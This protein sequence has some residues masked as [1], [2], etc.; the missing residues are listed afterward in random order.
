M[1]YGIYSDNE[2]LYPDSI[3]HEHGKKEIRLLAAKG[4]HAACQILFNGVEANRPIE[5]EIASSGR[6][7]CEVYRLIDIFVEKNTGPEEFCLKEGELAEGY[8]TRPAPFRVYDALKPFGGHEVTDKATEALYLAF[9]IDRTTNPGT[10]HASVRVTFGEERCEIPCTLEVFDAEVPSK[11]SL[12]IS[13]WFGIN[14]MASRYGLEKWSEAHWDMIRKYGVLMRRV[15]QT[16]FWIPSELIEARKNEDG[17]FSFDFGR[18]KRFVEMYL[19]LGFTYIEGNLIAYRVQFKDDHFVVNCCGDVIPA[20]SHEG[21]DYISQYLKAW[22]SFLIENGWLDITVQHVAD[23][24]TEACV[25]EYRILSGIVRKFMPGTKIIEAVEY[26]EPYDL[27]GSVD[28]WVPKNNLYQEYR[29]DFERFRRQGDELWFYTCCVPGGYFLNRLWDMPLIR[30]RYLH[31]GNYIYNLSGYLHWGLNF[32][33]SEEDPFNQRNL[34][35]PP[36]DTHI[37]YPGDDGPWG[38]M[39]FEAMRSG[40]ED[41]ELL[42]ML[43]K[44]NKPLADEIAA[45]CISSFNQYNEDTEQFEEARRSLLSALSEA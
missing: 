4:G 6:I 7:A 3:V 41:Y 10:Y 21:Y 22:R 19:E 40:I 34:F 17:S 45:C 18:I 32:C 13:N 14:N 37:V 26:P 27:D 2:W 9:R 15:R 44:I 39:R 1:K 24:P 35:F 30:T 28:I 38:S 5:V 43:E 25:G 42:K 16:H 12:H 29:E 36:G 33:A 20:L 11:E 8:T 23:E 31:W